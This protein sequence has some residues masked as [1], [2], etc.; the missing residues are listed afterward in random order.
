MNELILMGISVATSIWEIWMC[1]QVLL[2][3][4]IDDQHRK[5]ADK[6]IMWCTMI[7]VGFLLGLNRLIAFFSS[8]IFVLTNIIIIII[9][10]FL[11]RRKKVLC[12]GIII[13][14]FSLVAIFDM[15]LAFISYDILGKEFIS[16][17]YLYMTTWKREGVY[18][19]SRMVVCIG[20]YFLKKRLGN[21][22]ELAERCNRFIM[23]VGIILFIL[24]IKYQYVLDEMVIGDREQKGISASLGLVTTTVIIVLLEFFVLKYR[25]MKQEKDAILLRE[26]LLEERY[27]E[28]MKTRQVI[29]D[30]RNH[31]L[32]LQKYEKEQQWGKL[33]KYLEVISED[34]F[35]D[36]SRVWT[37]NAIVDMILNSKKIYAEERQIQVEIET[38][39]IPRFVLD[40]R[41]IISLFGN[42]LDNAIEACE[43]MQKNEKWIHI[44]LKK[45]HELLSIEIENSIEEVPKE[46]R[47]E[48]LS[49]KKSQEVHGYGLKN[50]QQ[51]VNKHDGAYSYQIKENSFLTSI[52][53]FDDGDFAL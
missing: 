39:V 49:D 26:Q 9:C 33:H 10:I 35:E 28:V 2:I 48:L 34:L 4:V 16:G 53:F 23:G 12:A 24:L 19:L 1:Y 40:N 38:E 37:G 5:N 25:H 29:H 22:Y 41:E 46:R 3:T 18:F 14:Y 15:A 52:V 50:V 20:I 42:L 7:C 32:L 47:G 13:L 43:K 36:S 11:N 44:S 27:I 8:P 45:H 31:F 6:I 21:M 17:V 30:M 51:I